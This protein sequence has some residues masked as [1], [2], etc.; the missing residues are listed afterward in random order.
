MKKPPRTYVM[1]ARAAKME[2]TR[3]RIL[4]DAAD[5][6]LERGIDEFTLEMVAQRAQT[7]VQ[8]ILR[9]HGNRDRLLFA[10]VDKLARNGVPLK[11]TPPGDIAAAVSAIFDLYETIGDMVMQWLADERRRPELRKTLDEGRNDHRNWV[12][13]AFGPQIEGCRKAVRARFFQ[14]LVVATDVYVW[15]KLR[16]E[17]GLDREAAEAVVRLIVDSLLQQEAT[18]GEAT[19]AELVGRRESPA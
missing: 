17:N 8:T 16:R 19:V 4:D 9:I 12:A 2:A 7:T 15:A 14:A 5:L 13:L 18:N 6:Y 11:P 1:S 10:V 3:K